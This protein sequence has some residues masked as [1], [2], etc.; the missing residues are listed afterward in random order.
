MIRESQMEA[1]L[2]IT[3]QTG[4]PLFDS[5]ARKNMKRVVLGLIMWQ[6]SHHKS[7]VCLLDEEMRR[8]LFHPAARQTAPV[9]AEWSPER[10]K[11][12][13]IEMSRNGNVKAKVK[14]G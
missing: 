7:K 1:I 12:T 8:L 9:D 11:A 14:H 13:N 4:M 2:G 3:Y 6:R 5:V 10:V